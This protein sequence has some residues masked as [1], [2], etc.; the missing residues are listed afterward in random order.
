MDLF[1][2]PRADLVDGPAV[3]ADFANEGGES[4]GENDGVIECSRRRGF[5]DYRGFVLQ[6]AVVRSFGR[7]H[8]GSLVAFVSAWANRRDVGNLDELRCCRH[9]Y[10]PLLKTTTFPGWRV[11]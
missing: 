8:G 11:I 9:F 1:A 5:D 4:V 7:K 6:R 10:S 3:S 2:D